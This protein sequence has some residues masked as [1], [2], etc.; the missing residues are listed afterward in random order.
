[1]SPHAKHKCSGWVA[2]ALIA[3]GWESPICLKDPPEGKTRSIPASRRD[4]LHAIKT[5]EERDIG[6]QDYRRAADCMNAK[7]CRRAEE[8]DTLVAFVGSTAYIKYPE[9]EFTMRWFLTAETKALQDGFD[10]GLEPP[11]RFDITLRAPRSA[12]RLTERRAKEGRRVEGKKAR[13]EKPRS[14]H[15]RDPKRSPKKPPTYDAT[16]RNGVLIARSLS[17]GS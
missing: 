12:E 17:V 7:A 13:G 1:M 11:A 5:L 15:T 6:V 4:Y 9:D 14:Y 3:S 16:V 2:A 10:R 8:G